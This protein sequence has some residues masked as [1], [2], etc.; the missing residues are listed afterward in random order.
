MT[1]Q[2]PFFPSEQGRGLQQ[3][4]CAPTFRTPFTSNPCR[5]PGTVERCLQHTVGQRNQPSLFFGPKT[6]S[7]VLEGGDFGYAWHLP[8]SPV[9]SDDWPLLGLILEGEYF[10]D[11]SLL[12]IRAELQPYP[13]Q[14]V[15]G[16][17]GI[18]TV[19]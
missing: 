14:P 10:V 15:G 6:E 16:H 18:C 19:Q 9:S 7:S 4:V 3:F 5:Q 17:H 11:K 13:V 8:S 1:Q 12:A 2:W